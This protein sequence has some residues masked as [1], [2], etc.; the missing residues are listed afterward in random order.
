M[1]RLE[2][3]IYFR[4]FREDKQT[5]NFS[6]GINIIYG[7]SGVGK[8][9][10]LEETQ[11]A[12]E[13]SKNN[14]V[15]TYLSNELKYY[16]IYQNPDHQIIASTVSKELTFS[17]ECKLLNPDELEKVFTPVFSESSPVSSDILQLGNNINT[18]IFLEY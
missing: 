12:K 8:T 15:L 1:T 7:E 6:K 2:G 11:G 14:F 18:E 9:N 17:G 3:T 5:F 4:K 16:R 13:L 10:F